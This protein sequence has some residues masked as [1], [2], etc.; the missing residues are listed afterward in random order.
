MT[1]I[2]AGKIITQRIR[3][4]KPIDVKKVIYTTSED[5]FERKDTVLDVAKDFRNRLIKPIADWKTGLPAYGEEGYNILRQNLASYTSYVEKLKQ[6]DAEKFVR[7][8]IGENQ[9]NA[10][11]EA[12][13]KNVDIRLFTETL[14]KS[15]G[16]TIRSV[17]IPN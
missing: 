12:G 9:L 15:L 1:N 5:I 3:S 2:R 17:I 6:P 16:K 10:L 7:L 8:A 14:E 4:N 13:K 11:E